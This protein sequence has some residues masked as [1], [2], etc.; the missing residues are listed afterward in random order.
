MLEKR[1][2]NKFGKHY[3]LGINKDN[4]YVW[5]EKET[6][7]CDWY[8]A[9]GYL[10]TYTNNLN[11]E[12]AKDLA[13][14]THFDYMFLRGSQC[15]R[16]MFKMYFKDTV[17]TD[18]EIWVLCDLMMTYYTLKKAAELFRNGY[19]HQT[20]LAKIDKLQSPMTADMINKVLLPEVFKKIE[21]LL[22]P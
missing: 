6:W 9:A 2:I 14:H 18:E 15:S 8:W 13:M 22:A 19:S 7:D 11:P 12:R 1:T 10:H 16:D 17:L 21:Q 3:L 20:A 5:L 4:D